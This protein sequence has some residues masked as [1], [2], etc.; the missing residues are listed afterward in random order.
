MPFSRFTK[1]PSEKRERL[2]TIAAQEFAAHGFEAASLNRILEEAQIGKSSAYY[3]FEDKADLFCAVVEYC[4]DRLQLSD[5]S[6][7][8]T[9][10]TAETFWAIL[11]ELHSRPLLRTQ[12][13]P[14]LLAA[15]RAVERLTPE[16][17]ERDPLANLAQRM[18]ANMG[19]VIKRGQ[20][21]GLIRSDLPDELLFDWFRAIDGASDNWLLAHMDRMDQATILHVS[22]QTMTALRQALAPPASIE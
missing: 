4:V 15:A 20:E 14:W 5:T 11:A 2:L 7:D 13:Q 1:M 9:T 21:L 17:L 12:Q 10:L 18:M 19:A 22:Q 8:V 6:V 16:A 3:Y